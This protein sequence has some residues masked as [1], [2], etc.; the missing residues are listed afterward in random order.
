MKLSSL[1]KIN[2]TFTLSKT[3]TK[4][5]IRFRDS[6]TSFHQIQFQSYKHVDAPPHTFTHPIRPLTL[7]K[8]LEQ[9]SIQWSCHPS[10]PSTCIPHE[11]R[12]GANQH[13][14]NS[15]MPHTHVCAAAGAYILYEVIRRRRR[16][17]VYV[18]YGSRAIVAWISVARNWFLCRAGLVDKNKRRKVHE[19]EVNTFTP[20]PLLTRSSFEMCGSGSLCSCSGGKNV[21]VCRC[22]CAC[23]CCAS[24]AALVSMWVSERSQV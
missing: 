14:H 3:H 5:G 4:V 22:V 23:V 9:L 13:T 24:V 17:W 16:R 6:R 12:N 2:R 19:T 7:P 15:H 20:L 1:N 21:C 18:V 10:V 11:K 8:T